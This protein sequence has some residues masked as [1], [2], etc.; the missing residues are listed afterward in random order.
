MISI[1]VVHVD[2]TGPYEVLSL[3]HGNLY[4]LLHCVDGS[5]TTAD[6]TRFCVRSPTAVRFDLGQCNSKFAQRMFRK[7]DLLIYRAT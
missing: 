5:E 7:G 6:V 2:Y 4:K 3:V 1:L